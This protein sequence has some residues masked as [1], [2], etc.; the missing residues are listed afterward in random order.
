MRILAELTKPD[1][2]RWQARIGHDRDRL[3]VVAIVPACAEPQVIALLSDSELR[4][5]LAE[6]SDGDG[7]WRCAECGAANARDRRWCTQCSGHTAA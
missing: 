6:G 1:G 7:E 4:A 2:A 5:L 3:E